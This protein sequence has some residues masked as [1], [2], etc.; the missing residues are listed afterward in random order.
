MC[1]TV[2][3]TGC[4]WTHT[5][6]LVYVMKLLLVLTAAGK[7]QSDMQNKIHTTRLWKTPSQVRDARKHMDN[8]PYT[9]SR[10][11][12]NSNWLVLINF[13]YTDTYGASQEVPGKQ[14][15]HCSKLMCHSCKLCNLMKKNLIFYFQLIVWSCSVISSKHHKMSLITHELQE[16]TC[17]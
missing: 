8:S 2:H 5:L 4:V 15:V 1:V 17:T 14:S 13:W 6:R 16:V 7:L 3:Q 10:W 11:I 12:L 9:C